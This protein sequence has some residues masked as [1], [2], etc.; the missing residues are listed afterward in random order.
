MS[1]SEKLRTVVRNYKAELI[2]GGCALAGMVGAVPAVLGA[3][4]AIN[5]AAYAP[6]YRG[7]AFSSL[8]LFA[9][10]GTAI[11]A[12]AFAAHKGVEGID[13]NKNTDRYIQN[14]LASQLQQGHEELCATGAKGQ[15]SVWLWGERQVDFEVC[16]RVVERFGPASLVEFKDEEGAVRRRLFMKDMTAGQYGSVDLI[17]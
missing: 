7:K 5:A 4:G 14:A 6:M 16:G 17:P 12:S 3:L 10:C 2:I 9:V 11:L 13:A 15:R 1:V 8:K